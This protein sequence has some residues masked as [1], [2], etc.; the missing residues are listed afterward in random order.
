MAKK[1]AKQTPE[2]EALE[3]AVI[4]AQDRGETSFQGTIWFGDTVLK[5]ITKKRADGSEFTTTVAILPGYYPEVQIAAY[6]EIQERFPSLNDPDRMK[7]QGFILG[8]E[9]PPKLL[10]VDVSLTDRQLAEQGDVKLPTA[11]VRQSQ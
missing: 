3:K 5:P 6:R 7:E 10:V 4:E 2:D 1:N 11:S 8:Q 9:E